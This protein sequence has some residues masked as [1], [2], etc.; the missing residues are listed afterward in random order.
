MGAFLEYLVKRSRLLSALMLT[1]MAALVVADVLIPTGYG[2]FPW[3]TIGGFGALYGFVS[4]V[5]IVVV[6][7]A[8]GYAWLYRP[9]DYYDKRT[10]PDSEFSARS[11]ADESSSNGTRGTS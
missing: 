1:F 3:D 7:K 11:L 2:R 9:E 4:C 5:L 6:S 10:P 8:L